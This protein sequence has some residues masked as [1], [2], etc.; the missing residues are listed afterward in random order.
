MNKKKRK[1]TE[2]HLFLFAFLFVVISNSNAQSTK[3]KIASI[4]TTV[5]GSAIAIKWTVTNT[6][7]TTKSFGVSAEIRQNSTLLKDLGSKFT[8]KIAPGAS[9]TVFFT[10]TIPANWKSGT[11]IG[12][13][14]AWDGAAGSSKRLY[15]DDQKF[16]VQA[17]VTSALV[18]IW[19]MTS[20]GNSL[21]INYS[22]KN[23]GNY[24]RS[25]SIGV[26]IRRYPLMHSI[27][28]SGIQSTNII[29]PGGTATY[30]FNED[31]SSILQGYAYGTVTATVM[32][33]RLAG[34]G[35]LCAAW[36]YCPNFP[37]L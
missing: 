15:T 34:S 25:Y 19:S 2:F 11:Y 24:P 17:R 28:M 3:F 20:Y 9:A 5:A 26:E 37:A 4:P 6:G 31:I 32:V 18:S 35:L 36:H 33:Y 13:T 16:I 8:T 1:F 12:H 7:T 10:Y 23:T 21:N 27:W 22:V 14:A 29:E 30:T